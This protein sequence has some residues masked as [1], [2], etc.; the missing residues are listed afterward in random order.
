[1]VVI[2]DWNDVE[3]AAIAAMDGNET[4]ITGQS[5]TDREQVFELLT[6]MDGRGKLVARREGE[7][8]EKIPIHLTCSLGLFGEPAREKAV[9]SAAAK[10]LRELEGVEWRARR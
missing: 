4:T 9:M 6:I 2:G 7:G 10:R 5:A 8:V 3:A 1:V